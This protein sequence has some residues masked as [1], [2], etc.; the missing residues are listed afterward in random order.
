MSASSIFTETAGGAKK[1]EQSS[2]TPFRSI[3]GRDDYSSAWRTIRTRGMMKD[4]FRNS[5][6]Y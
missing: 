4:T 1:I 5:K 3:D 2:L 6:F